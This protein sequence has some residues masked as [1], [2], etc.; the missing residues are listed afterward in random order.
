MKLF[1]SWDKTPWFLD[2]ANLIPGIASLVTVD[3]WTAATGA[4]DPIQIPI[5]LSTT[6]F[7]IMAAA[8]GIAI[9]LTV[10]YTL[11]RIRAMRISKDPNDRTLFKVVTGC[12]V[13]LLATEALVITPYTMTVMAT[14][15]TGVTLLQL[16]VAEQPILFWVWALFVSDA[17]LLAVVT[18]GL[19]SFVVDAKTIPVVSQPE[20]AKP[21]RVRKSVAIPTQVTI[22]PNDGQNAPETIEVPL[23]P[24]APQIPNAVR[25]RFRANQAGAK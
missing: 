20:I 5:A 8:R 25:A 11:N 19:A 16:K 22:V 14:T 23:A 1:P 4:A 24:N 13:A 6:P 7:S 12:I 10:A 2:P 21:A 15:P 3:Q 18:S 9:V 17:A